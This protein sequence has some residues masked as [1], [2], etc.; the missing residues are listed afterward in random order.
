MTPYTALVIEDNKMNLELITDVL[1]L[2]GFK[3]LTAG[4]AYSGMAVA[5]RSKPDIILMARQ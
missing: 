1:E 3:V 5:S 4:E 2:D